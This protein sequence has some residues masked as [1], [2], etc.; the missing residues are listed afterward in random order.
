MG[1]L[2]QDYLTLIDYARRLDKNG[3]APRF[4]EQMMI[5]GADDLIRNMIVKGTNYELTETTTVRTGLP[6]VAA[7]QFGEGWKASKS[8]TAQESFTCA[9]FHGRSQIDK[10]LLDKMPNGSAFFN[11][12]VS[13]QMEAMYQKLATTLFYGNK[14]TV[15]NEFTGLAAYYSS[16]TAKSARNLI[17]ADGTGASSYLT[18]I[19]LV[20]WGPDKVYGIFPQASKAGISHEKKP[21]QW[22]AD[23]SG[24]AE[25]KYWVAVDE[26]EANLGLCVAD[27][28]YAGRIANI[29]LDKNNTVGDTSDIS[30]NI[31]KNMMYLK[32]RVPNL[33]SGKAVFYMNTDMMSILETMMLEKTS[34]STLAYKD[35]ADGRQVL[36]AHGV[37]VNR[38]DSI[39]N[40][41][42]LVS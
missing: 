13:A 10:R 36:T 7:A 5:L 35:L 34:G 4:I 42:T 30:S 28:R 1:V 15:A 40:T 11:S 37:E 23:A 3:I 19:Y 26:Y 12:E 8:A 2:N 31:L 41:E 20:V 22:V 32:N 25:S 14:K 6:T 38:V 29:D 24:D 17:L 16:T 18:S 9:E 39:V 27:W 33:A 21:D